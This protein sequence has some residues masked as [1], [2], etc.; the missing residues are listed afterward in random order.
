MP[1][2]RHEL[3]DDEQLCFVHIPKSGGT[4][5]DAVLRHMFG[6][7]RVFTVPWQ[8]F[9]HDSTLVLNKPKDL[10]RYKALTGHVYFDEFSKLAKRPVYAT[11]LRDP[12][13]RALS[14]YSQCRRDPNYR[15]YER[16]QSM[17]IEEYL[18]T[19]GFFGAVT[20][21]STRMLSVQFD[22]PIHS[23]NDLSIASRKTGSN[24]SLDLAKEHLRECAFFGLT[25]RF[26]DSVNLFAYIF[27]LPPMREIPKLRAAPKRS[28]R[29]QLSSQAL[30]R[31]YE[32][33]QDDIEL[34]AYAQEL[35][36]DRYTRMREEL[37]K[38]FSDGN[39]A[40]TQSTI[41]ELLERDYLLHST[42][43]D[44]KLTDTFIYDFHHPFPRSGWYPSEEVGER[45]WTWSGPGTVSTIDLPL[46]RT[47]NLKIRLIVQYAAASDILESLTLFIDDEP[48]SLTRSRGSDGTTIFQGV[49]P[50]VIPSLVGIDC[51]GLSRL[52]FRVNRTAYPPNIDPNSPEARLLGIAASWIEISPAE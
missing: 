31:L 38:R 50:C 29:T 9:V 25:E 45:R 22:A 6:R 30:D 49:I 43:R 41:E 47:V 33:N 52:I 40:D 27:R 21:V 12:I 20:N 18:G 14:Q 4:S 3:K 26:Q 51:R 44:L 28:D 24:P 39:G 15:N 32:L 5:F 42:E 19:P 23:L 37:Q 17:S 1:S 13:E 36:E 2:T 10:T 8:F 34:Y 7:D 11:F 16:M 35:F 46:D 48:V